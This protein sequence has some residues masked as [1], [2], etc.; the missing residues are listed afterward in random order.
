MVKQISPIYL[1][2]KVGDELIEINGESTFNM[3]HG[4]AIDAIKRGGNSLNVVVRRSG[5]QAYMSKYRKNWFC[6]SSSFTIVSLPKS[7]RDSSD[8]YFSI[9]ANTLPNGGHNTGVRRQQRFYY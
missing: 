4:D 6:C 3:N 2:V 8:L 5:K 9:A 7:F 1:F